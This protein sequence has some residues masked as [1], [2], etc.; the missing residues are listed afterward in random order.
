MPRFTYKS[1][2][3]TSDEK[4]RQL[5]LYVAHKTKDDPRCGA[6]KF[7]KLLFY[8]EFTSYRLYGHT[9][10]NAEYQHLAE[11]PAPRR[12]LPLRT[13]LLEEGAITME[14]LPSPIGEPLQK[15]LPKK[16]PKT[17]ALSGDDRN[18]IDNVVDFF[19]NL[20]GTEISD[21]S[22]REYAWRLTTEGQ[23]IAFS[24]AWLSAEPLTI[25][26]IELGK[27]IASRHGLTV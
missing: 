1:K 11:G 14:H 27:E 7:N 24:T 17:P 26:Q 22:H 4:L 19:W 10:T 25:D 9:I 21:Q 23:T 18:V 15:L 2:S 3:H 20:N 8:S 6:V 13:L 5:I 16:N 12:L